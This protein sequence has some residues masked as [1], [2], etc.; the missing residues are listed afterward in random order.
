MV[1]TDLKRG[2]FR[3][4]V[5]VEKIVLISC[6]APGCGVCEE[7]APVFERVAERYP[8]HV[9]ARMNVLTDEKLGEFFEIDHTPALMVY[10]DSLL[11]LKKPGVFSEESLTDIIR[12]TE[13]LDMDVVRADVALEESGSEK[14]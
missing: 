4:V 2:N 10:R 9:F 1:L 11:L 8:D 6:W 12:Q 13:S 3:K 5:G 14:S 7:F